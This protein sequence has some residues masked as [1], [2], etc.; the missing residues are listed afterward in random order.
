[1][2]T[3]YMDGPLWLTKVPIGWRADSIIL[4][5]RKCW[6]I[7]PITQYLSTINNQNNINV[8]KF[9]DRLDHSANRLHNGLNDQI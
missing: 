8:V 2:Q 7:F 1:M 5:T 9:G 3:Q 4:G 6:S